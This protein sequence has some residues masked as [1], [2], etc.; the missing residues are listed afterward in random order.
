MLKMYRL[1]LQ[2]CLPKLPEVYLNQPKQMI[3]E[4]LREKRSSRK[5]A[6]HLGVSH[7]MVARV[8]RRAGLKPHRIER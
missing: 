3:S 4:Y 7:M 2:V 8:W 5:L 6:Q 1:Q